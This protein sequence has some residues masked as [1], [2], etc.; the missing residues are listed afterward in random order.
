MTFHSDNHG[1]GFDPSHIKSFLAGHGIDLDIQES[2]YAT[3]K[4]ARPAAP[5]V[6]AES[7][8][9]PADLP[10]ELYA[11]NNAFRAVTHGHG[12]PL[13]TFKNRLIG[14]L[15]KQFPDLSDDAV[16]RIATVAN[17][18]KAPG[19]KKSNAE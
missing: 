13:A 2:P 14:Y 12:D 17:P 7:D 1:Y 3:A 6:V 18:N 16:K 11:A 5:E 10:D 4:E 9:D 15:E 8:I 19:R